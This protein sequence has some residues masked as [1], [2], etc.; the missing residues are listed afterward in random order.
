ME[1]VK[2]SRKGQ[3]VVPQDLRKLLGFN[4][5]DL[6]I[7]HG[8]KDYVV[9]KKVQLPSLKQEFEEL[10]NRTAM[11]A[12]QKGVTEGTVVEEVQKYRKEKRRRK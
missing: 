1:L 10:V 12:E 9:F 5:E 4:E 2:M 7:A 6:F 3:L 8:A 11:I